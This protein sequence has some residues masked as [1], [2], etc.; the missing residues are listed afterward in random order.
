MIVLKSFRIPSQ[1]FLYNSRVILIVYQRF[2]IDIA[3]CGLV[4][5]GLSSF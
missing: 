1:P 2:Q 4:A 5:A 3:E